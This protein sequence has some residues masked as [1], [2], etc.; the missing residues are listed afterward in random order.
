MYTHLYFIFLILCDWNIVNIQFCT[1]VSN[2]NL[3]FIMFFSKLFS[4]I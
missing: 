4:S 1:M 2:E 3:R